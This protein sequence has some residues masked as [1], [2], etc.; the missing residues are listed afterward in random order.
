ML[1]L[2]ADENLNNNI[3]RG[4]MR[5][6]PDIDII[7]IQDI[8]LSGAD[9]SNVLDWAAKNGR[10]L[11]THDAATITKYAYERILA[12]LSM[13]GVFEININASIGKI[14]EDLL[15]ITEY[16]IE[17]EWNNRIEYLPLK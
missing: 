4:L 11:L 15:L 14:I 6:K 5:R 3:I 8:G 13:P 10:I 9:D 2:A 7:R 16:S 12:G 17:D 1:R